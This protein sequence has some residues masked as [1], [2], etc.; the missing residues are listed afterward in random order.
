M[1]SGKP[2]FSLFLSL[3]STEMHLKHFVYWALYLNGPNP[4]LPVRAFL[5][6]A[7]L[8]LAASKNDSN[9]NKPHRNGRKEG[10]RRENNKQK[11]SF[12]LKRQ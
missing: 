6:V 2:C 11:L 4:M 1:A 3:I 7:S 10:G 9:N 5:S 12:L 8:K